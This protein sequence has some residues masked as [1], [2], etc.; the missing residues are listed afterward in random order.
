MKKCKIFLLVFIFSFQNYFLAQASEPFRF[1]LLS[2]L[3]V[4]PNDPEP[5][6]DL[7]NAVNDVNALK[8]IDFVLITGDVSNFGDTVSLKAAKQMLEKLHMP[9]YI[10]PGNH[11]LKWNEPG[12][13]NFIKVFHDDKF[14]FKHKGFLFIGFATAPL[15]NSTNGYI[16]KQDIDWMKTILKKSGKKI[17]FFAVTHYPLQ[18]GDV[19][20]W[21]DMTDVLKKYNI[22]AILNGHYHRNVILNE[23]GIPGIVTRSTMRS[24]KT[25]GGYSVFSLSDSVRVYEKRIGVAEDLWLTL[26]LVNRR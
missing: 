11:D 26:P 6:E 22:Q 8:G 10:I 17:P 4:N 24:K 3:H 5:A 16:Q 7:Q 23:D 20:N 2:D 1:A 18:T 12:A 25:V 9:F 13:T 15:T 14:R 21:K 19:D